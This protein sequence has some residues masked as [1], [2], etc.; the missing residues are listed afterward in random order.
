MRDLPENSFHN[1]PSHIIKKKKPTT[2]VV[3][4]INKYELGTPAA[5]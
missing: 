3:V 2:P 4:R 1:A 5:A